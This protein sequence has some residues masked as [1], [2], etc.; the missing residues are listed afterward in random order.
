[1]RHRTTGCLFAAAAAVATVL[2][3]FNSSWIVKRVVSNKYGHAPCPPFSDV[4]GA[5]V[6]D[7]AA[8]LG[9]CTL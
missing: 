1:M 7:F 4:S 3:L 8:C 2:V 5:P 6:D 9:G